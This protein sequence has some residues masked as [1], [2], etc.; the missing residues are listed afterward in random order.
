M[1]YEGTSSAFAYESITVAATAIGFTTATCRPTNA[2]AA[3]RAICS[4]ETGQIRFRYDGTDP[5]AAEGH[6][7]DTSRTLEVVGIQN[8]LNFRAI[9]T[10]ATSGI[11]KVTYER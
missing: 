4:L 11:L 7:L 6:I 8:I 10:G 2:P 3:S 9:A 5:T 1:P